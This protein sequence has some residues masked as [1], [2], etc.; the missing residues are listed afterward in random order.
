M[1]DGERGRSGICG[2]RQ[3][4]VVRRRWPMVAHQYL[5]LK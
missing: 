3:G 5:K 2:L 4:F 1:L